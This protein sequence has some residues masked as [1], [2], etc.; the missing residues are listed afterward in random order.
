MPVPTKFKY[1]NRTLLGR[2]ED[3]MPLPAWTDGQIVVSRWQFTF[4]ERLQ[5]LIT[6]KLWITLLSGST[7]PPIALDTMRNLLVPVENTERD[8]VRKRL[9]SIWNNGT[10]S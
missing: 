9:K 4:R 10:K 6:G 3:V 5:L 1:Q 7:Q 2:T 8:T